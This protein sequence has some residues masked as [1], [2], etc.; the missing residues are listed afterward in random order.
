[1]LP[2]KAF[3]YIA[4]GLPILTFPHRTLKDFVEK[5]KVGIVVDD[6]NFK[7]KLVDAEDLRENVMKKRFDYTVEGKINDLTD[8]YEKI[9]DSHVYH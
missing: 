1:M 8:F 5:E 6:L 9:I 3:E 7:E 4:C 2:N